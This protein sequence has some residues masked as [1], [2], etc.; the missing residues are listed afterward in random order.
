MIYKYLRQLL[1]CLPPEV[2]HK[3]TLSV[4]SNI[5]KLM[6]I[7]APCVPRQVMGLQF[8]NPVGIA[9]GFDKNAEYLSAWRLLG[10]GF[11]EV[12]SITLKPRQG[13]PK[14]RLFRLPR[15]Q[16]LINRIGLANHGVDAI[17]PRLIKH[18]FPG[19]LGVNIGKEEHA[20]TPTEVCKAYQQVLARV[21]SAADY[22]AF[23]LSCPHEPNL[24]D[25]QFGSELELL[26]D[27]LKNAQTK[28]THQHNKYVP[29]AIKL[30]PELTSEEV[31]AIAEKLLAYEIDGVIASNTTNARSLVEH[32]PV[33]RERGGLSGKP[34]FM[35]STELCRQLA[36]ALGGK[37]PIIATGGIMSAAHASEKIAAGA[38]L[39]QIYTG[40]NNLPRPKW[41]ILIPTICKT[42]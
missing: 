39:V 17:L 35:S 7:K 33:A 27:G 1:F 42:R 8:P 12:G 13:F 4:L 20:E 31:D 37:I 28:L 2:A 9:A 34:L 10:A 19:I 41:K 11:V 14:P 15:Q 18:D 5:A 22:V 24:R 32:L 26:L 30:S 3:V 38:S 21:Y 36:Q 25:L 23:N 29:I 6:S 40:L 16:T